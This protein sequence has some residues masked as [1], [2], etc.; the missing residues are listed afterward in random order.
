MP[1]ELPW[2]KRAQA[3]QHRDD[4]APQEHERSPARIETRDENREDSAHTDHRDS[5][6][7]VSGARD[8]S[9]S[10]VK[11]SLSDNVL[12]HKVVILVGNTEFCS[13]WTFV[14]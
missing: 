1:V 13:S 12:P 7:P 14:I 4:N 10:T 11:I 9:T 6:Q 8:A 5:G 2:N 3:C